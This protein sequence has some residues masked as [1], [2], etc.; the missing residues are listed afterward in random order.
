MG[1][2]LT[3][4][5]GSVL[6]ALIV[7][8]FII[9]IARLLNYVDAPGVRHVHVKPIP[10]IG[11]VA[12]LVSMI[13][14]L[15]CVP[16]LS[17]FVWSAFLKIALELS[18]LLCSSILVFFVGLIGDVKSIRARTSFFTLLG[19]AVAVC[20]AGIRIQSVVVTD[21]LTIEFGWCSWPLTISW[22]MGITLAVN[23]S[24]GLDGLAAGISSIACGVIAIFAVHSGNAVMAA[25]MLALL[26]SLTGF[27]FFNFNPAKIFL[28][29]C[30]G[31]F[32]GF[33]IASSSVLCSAKSP[34]LVGLA[35]PVLALGIPIFDT[36][37][38]ILR[39]FLERR[40]LFAPDRRHFHHRLIDF[41]LEQRRAVIVM[42]LVTL[43]AAG[44]GLLMMVTPSGSSMIVFFC[45]LL[46]LLLIFNV[47]GAIPLREVVRSLKEKCTI[48]R[49]QRKETKSFEKAELHFRRVKTFGQWWQ[50]LSQAASEMDLLNMRLPLTD[51]DG[52]R[53]MLTWQGCEQALDSDTAMLRGSIPVQDRRSDSLLAL[54]VTVSADVSSE[55]A[56][57]R[58]ALFSRLV[59]EQPLPD[60][61][62]RPELK[63]ESEKLS[64]ISRFFGLCVVVCDT[65]NEQVHM[66]INEGDN[67]RDKYEAGQVGA[68]G[69]D[70]HAH[71][72]TFNQLWNDCHKDV[73]L[74]VLANELE[75]VR[76]KMASQAGDSVEAAVAGG[77]IAKAEIA[78][79]QDDGPRVMRHLKS[80]GKWALDFATSVGSSLVAEVI[81]K[82]MGM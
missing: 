38:S 63:P 30:G 58:L 67:V 27:L 17:N 18:V 66:H 16:L 33:I 74:S 56:A 44:A 64:W 32:L 73:N 62:V 55:S 2:Y 15:L 28:G 72:M 80:A 70:A 24:D 81:K 78:A 13:S 23:L 48:S 79:K 46:F 8:P 71:D 14:V 36:L 7:T 69:P 61:K 20:A 53:H 22:I 10:R 4:Y 75:L 35:L 3:L 40:S 26:G 39:R 82:S 60:E 54:S 31:M 41:G 59:D 29:D 9:R 21:S 12:I 51:R 11:G 47:I 1:T 43:L 68:Q 57:R 76:K 49:Q 65:Y 6:V 25:L 77:E 45:T 42:Y 37:F 52:T 19:A 34:V 50:A 5:C